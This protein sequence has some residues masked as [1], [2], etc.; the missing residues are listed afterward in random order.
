M[1]SAAGSPHVSATMLSIV[2]ASECV[3]GLGNMLVISFGLLCSSCLGGDSGLVY[4]SFCSLFGFDAGRLSF[5][6]A[7]KKIRFVVNV[8]HGEFIDS[9]IHLCSNISLALLYA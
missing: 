5:T 1:M 6:L 8:L 9:F 7:G 2:V 4:R 3:L